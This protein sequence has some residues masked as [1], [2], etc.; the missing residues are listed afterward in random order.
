MKAL[1]I[2]MGS[3]ALML[4]VATTGY[5]QCSGQFTYAVPRGNGIA[6]PVK[7]TNGTGD[8]ST[9]YCPDGTGIANVTIV[10]ESVGTFTFTNN[11]GFMLSH[12]FTEA[13]RDNATPHVFALPVTAN[14]TFSMISSIEC[15]NPKNSN[16]TF[17]LAPELQLTSSA[18]GAAVCPGAPVRL[19]ASGGTSEYILLRNGVEIARNITGIFDINPITSSTYSVR[20]STANCANGSAVQSIRVDTNNLTLSSSAA[21][22]NNNVS[23]G[24][25]V[26][27]IAGGGA[28]GS[29]YVWTANGV[30]L[31]GQTT[32]TI[33]QNPIVTTR[34][35]VS[36]IT[37]QGSCASSVAVVITV[38]NIPLPVELISFTAQW[39]EKMP[40]LFWVTAME[41][42][43]AYF[44]IERSYDGR[45]F[46]AIGKREAAG[47][48]SSRTNY[49]FVDDKLRQ[50][51]TAT[52]YYRLRQVD[53]DGTFVYSPV[54][55][56]RVAGAAQVFNAEAFPNPYDKTMSVQFNAFGTDAVTL[57]VRNVLGQ[58][59]LTKTVIAAAGVHKEEISEAGALPLGMYYLTIRQGGQQQVVRVSH[60]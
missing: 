25:S 14:S 3:L 24:G 16:V 51:T 40:T 32:A 1:T 58:T 44:D 47:T 56:L 45:T 6:A 19:T 59:V 48:T 27:L 52:V 28:A 60:R 55:T 31:A 33:T 43:S 38:N 35:V 39:N 46:S 10:S 57:T 11:T 41:K 7:V 50:G 20:T 22:A 49:Q 15:N 37:A 23:T 12:R 9:T 4:G 53:V 8:F 42:N 34:Y 2:F 36:G 54:R 30:T 18:G 21:T 26:T 29:S 17:N 13:E 5:G